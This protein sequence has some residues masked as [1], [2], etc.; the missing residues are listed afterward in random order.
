M[1]APS[2]GYSS[3]IIPSVFDSSVSGAV[4]QAIRE[5]KPS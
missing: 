3:Y 5:A 4:A 2:P 1:A